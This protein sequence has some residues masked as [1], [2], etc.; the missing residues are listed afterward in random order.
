MTIDKRRAAPAHPPGRR[1]FALGPVRLEAAL[2]AAAL[3]FCAVFL[4]GGFGEAG[5][6]HVASAFH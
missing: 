4:F 5:S 3:A 1:R 6:F 2:F